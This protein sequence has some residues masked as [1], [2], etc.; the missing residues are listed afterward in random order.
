MADDRVELL[1]EL[2]E[3]SGISGYEEEIR[4]IIK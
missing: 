1:R 4:K 2:T 3:A